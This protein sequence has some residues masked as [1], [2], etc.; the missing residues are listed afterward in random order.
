MDSTRVEIRRSQINGGELK[1]KLTVS[2]NME[3]E[4]V[5]FRKSEG[6]IRFHRLTDACSEEKSVRDFSQELTSGFVRSLC[7]P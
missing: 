2:K 3:N 6:K 5:R 4:V 1:W 7:L